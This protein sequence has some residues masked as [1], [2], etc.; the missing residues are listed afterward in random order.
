MEHNRVSVD[1][2]TDKSK[3]VRYASA[4]RSFLWMVT[5]SLSP[6]ILLTHLTH[7]TRFITLDVLLV[8][9]SMLR[10]KNSGGIQTVQR[11]LYCSSISLDLGL[12]VSRELPSSDTLTGD[13]DVEALE[14]V[15]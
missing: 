11:R 8:A 2:T 9:T 5:S 13:I 15:L 6:G 10:L 7:T 14:Q 1:K 3:I 12:R 4:L